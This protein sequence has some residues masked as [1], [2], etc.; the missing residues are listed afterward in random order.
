MKNIVTKCLVMG[1]L[2]IG[3]SS[4]VMALKEV[5]KPAHA[6]KLTPVAFEITEGDKTAHALLLL[7]QT[8]DVEGVVCVTDAGIAV[9]EDDC[10]RVK[11]RAG[12][13]GDHTSF[14]LRGD[15]LLNYKHTELHILVTLDATD[16]KSAVAS[17]LASLTQDYIPG[18]PSLPPVA[19][20]MAPA[21]AVSRIP[22]TFNN[23]TFSVPNQIVASQQGFTIPYAPDTRHV[24][25][26][27]CG[28]LA[29]V[30]GCF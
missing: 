24:G 25:L 2:A 7:G 22:V 19:I 21:A 15:D 26:P 14:S 30:T 6:G 1:A 16:T 9:S 20:V 23:G 3:M 28:G 11:G 13:Y 4:P 27:A 10:T 12:Q 5:V 8:G 29:G 17:Y 18:T